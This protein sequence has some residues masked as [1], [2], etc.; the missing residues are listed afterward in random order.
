MITPYFGPAEKD[1]VGERVI[2]M[3]V[4]GSWDE[5]YDDL[6][7][8]NP[9][10]YMLTP[11]VALVD[12]DRNE[13]MYYKT[14]SI[15]N[16]WGD[17][18]K[19]ATVNIPNYHWDSTVN[20]YDNMAD[21]VTSLG[22]NG[23]NGM[24]A[25]RIEHDNGLNWGLLNKKDSHYD[26]AYE[27]VALQSLQ[28]NND[29]NSAYTFIN[30]DHNNYEHSQSLNGNIGK[31]L[32]NKQNT[33]ISYEIQAPKTVADQANTV[34][35]TNKFVSIPYATLNV[36]AQ[37]LDFYH[38]PIYSYKDWINTALD[39]PLNQSFKGQVYSINSDENLSEYNNPSAYATKI[40]NYQ[41]S[42]TS[43]GG[44]NWQMDGY[45]GSVDAINVDRYY[46]LLSNM[47]AS[48]GKY[49]LSAKAGYG[50]S[51]P[52]QYT[53]LEYM[54]HVAT[55]A[56]K[57]QAQ[58]NN[59]FDD[60]YI[61]DA[62]NENLTFDYKSTVPAVN[63]EVSTGLIS[64][65]LAAMVNKVKAVDKTVTH[66]GYGDTNADYQAL[67][68][69]EQND[70]DYL[71]NYMSTLR[72][73]SSMYPVLTQVSFEPQAKVFKNGHQVYAS[74]ADGTDGFNRSY[75]K[76]DLPQGIYP[77]RFYGNYGDVKIDVNDW[78]VKLIG[79]RLLTKGGDD[80]NDEI[81]VEGALSGD[82]ADDTETLKS[83]YHLTKEQA[84]KLHS[85]LSNNDK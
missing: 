10:V 13:T 39:N 29:F 52:F 45:R 48:S 5:R 41:E 14:K 44:T 4:N 65:S 46:G 79:K 83:R 43:N 6:Q 59:L 69:S 25:S 2:D 28:T 82:S 66:Y 26:S 23:S 20:G 12:S 24:H 77:I 31:L 75:I 40:P 78:E 74:K 17:K 42:H 21:G 27:N 73:I 64:P 51:Y 57:F 11:V 80:K 19:D 18:P 8:K 15:F 63:Y 50:I 35:Q 22:W 1:A 54:S 71:I 70:V 9:D 55:K 34:S 81:S 60:L 68:K 16:T 76:S 3:H 32:D 72:G 33:S 36:F 85:F 38:E 49:V 37:S 58:A 7:I 30:M 47:D 56:P 61:K 53:I 62:N 67:N 84:E